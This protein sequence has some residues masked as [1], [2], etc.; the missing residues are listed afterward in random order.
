MSSGK[1]HLTLKRVHT[2][3][4][5]HLTKVLRLCC[6]RGPKCMIITRMWS[7][8]ATKGKKDE[9]GWHTHSKAEAWRSLQL[10]T[11][12]DSGHPQ[13]PALIKKN[14]LKFSSF[15]VYLN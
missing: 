13:I 14:Q 6:R 1:A 3:Q 4:Q 5:C 7:E 10:F 8:E 15:H 11:Y 12:A 9:L 2:S